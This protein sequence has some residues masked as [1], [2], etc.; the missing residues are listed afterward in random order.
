[1]IKSPVCTHT[2]KHKVGGMVGA[3]LSSSVCFLQ[4]SDEFVRENYFKAADP[5]DPYNYR[6]RAFVFHLTAYSALLLFVTP[7]LSPPR[8]GIMEN[9]FAPPPKVPRF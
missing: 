6:S 7:P 3:Y 8:G 4:F 9:L 2:A 1:M 5:A